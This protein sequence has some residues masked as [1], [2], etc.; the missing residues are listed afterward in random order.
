MLQY[1]QS[2]HG[3]HLEDEIRCSSYFDTAESPKK[4]VAT[5]MFPRSDW[6][7]G[8]SVGDLIEYKLM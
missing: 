1:L 2:K 7:V 6:P 4:K 8:V 3:S 5:E